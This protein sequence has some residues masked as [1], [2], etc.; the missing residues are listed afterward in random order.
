MAFYTKPSSP[1]KG[2]DNLATLDKSQLLLVT[3]VANDAYFSDGSNWKYVVV[4]YKSDVGNQIQTLIF[5]GKVANPTASFNP[6]EKARD[7]FEVQSVTIY[8][9]DS[10]KLSLLRD[11]LVVGDF[12]VDFS[13]GS[14]GVSYDVAALNTTFG[15]TFNSTTTPTRGNMIS[16]LSDG[17]VIIGYNGF[18]SNSIRK[19]NPDGSLDATFA[20]NFVDSGSPSVVFVDSNDNIY[21]SVQNTN[22]KK[23]D[24]D[25]NVISSFETNYGTYTGIINKMVEMP[26]GS[27]V[28]IGDLSFGY[29]ERINPDGTTFTGNSFNTNVSGNFGDNRIYNGGLLSDNTLVLVSGFTYDDGVNS[30]STQLVVLNDDGTLNLAKTNLY[31]NNNTQG[32][33][34]D[35][36]KLRIVND[37][38]Y[39][40]GGSQGLSGNRSFGV[41]LSDGNI[42]TT[43][44]NNVIAIESFSTDVL[45][46]FIFADNGRIIA[47]GSFQ[48]LGGNNDRDF[49]IALNSDGTL[50][51]D[52][53]VNNLDSLNFTFTYFGNGAINGEFNSNTFFINYEGEIDNTYPFFIAVSNT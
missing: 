8:D 22:F 1:T 43:F 4:K 9:F 28:L 35:T 42:D 2:Q 49:F 50:D 53:T 18:G 10:G 41:I 25:G 24:S 47:I 44:Q 23:M 52:F 26:D 31:T 6:T 3:K 46:D 39:G 7:T 11:E 37:N 34:S 15:S 45:K 17:S 40:I 20:S 12:D 19:F 14:G 30:F 33:D 16:F 5:D 21:Y 51:S 27:I 13:G 36:I 38:L 29:L 32:F 48:N